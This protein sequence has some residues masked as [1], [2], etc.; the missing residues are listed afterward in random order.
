M[1]KKSHITFPIGEHVVTLHRDEIRRLYDELCGGERVYTV[2]FDNK[3]HNITAD[4]YG[5]IRKQLE[6]K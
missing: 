4:T 5:S 1:N 6:D 3:L 2:S